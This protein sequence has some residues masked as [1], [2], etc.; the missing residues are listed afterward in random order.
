MTPQIQKIFVC[1][2]F[3]PKLRIW[4]ESTDQIP[5]DGYQEAE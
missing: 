1:K 5:G 2:G 3:S 4:S